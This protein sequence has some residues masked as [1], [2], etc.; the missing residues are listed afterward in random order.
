MTTF[1]YPV[2]GTH[3]AS[4]SYGNVVFSQ[5]NTMIFSDTVKSLF[6]IPKPYQILEIMVDTLVVFNA[7]TTN[8]LNL[9]I[10]GDADRFAAALAIGPLG[11]VLASSDV[12]ELANL[13]DLTDDG[14]VIE[15]F[16]T[17]AQTG[18]AA[19]TGSA[20]ITIT[21]AMIKQPVV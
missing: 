13:V 7:A 6:K 5:S 20:R 17:Y 2:R 14:D 15:I 1:Q 9:G 18:A 16:G 21:Y 11:R 8:T 19:T 10:T 3:K 4:D 12:S